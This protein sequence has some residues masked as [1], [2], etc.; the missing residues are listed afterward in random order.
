[1]EDKEFVEAVE[2]CKFP[3]EQFNHEKH[4]HLAWFYLRKFE[5]PEA[6]IKCR[7]TL[8]R[9]AA[10]YDKGQVYHET[11]TFAF[12]LLVHEGIRNR[13][14]AVTWDEFA[15]FNG[16]LLKGGKKFL[17]HLYTEDAL[18][19]SE[20]KKFFRFPDIKINIGESSWKNTQLK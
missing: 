18:N 1:M 6:I 12:M 16:S 9:F 15:A 5:L 2:N 13:P 14:E 20:S 10:H 19:S 7:D 3:L 17:S 4:V 8:K 11:I